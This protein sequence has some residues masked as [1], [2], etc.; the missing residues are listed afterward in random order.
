MRLGVI[1]GMGVFAGLKFVQI[2]SEGSISINET[3]GVDIILDNTTST[4][5]RTRH[6]LYD[7][8]SPVQSIIQR[9]KQLEKLHIDLIAIPCNSACCFLH[10]IKK[11]VDT[12]I[13]DIISLTVHSVIKYRDQIKNPL[14]LSGRVPYSLSVYHDKFQSHGLKAVSLLEKEQLSVESII[15]T[16]KTMSMNVKIMH[17]Y[18]RLISYLKSRY[19]FDAV[20]LGCT[21]FSLLS[22]EDIGVPT[23]DSNQILA[24]EVIKIHESSRS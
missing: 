11:S 10:E 17:E 18:H 16:L 24:K 6:V 14:I 20:I 8:K 7:E 4:P 22:E 13:L 21:E 5:S 3:E 2:V 15:S 19:E 1:G 23:F 12:E 9:C